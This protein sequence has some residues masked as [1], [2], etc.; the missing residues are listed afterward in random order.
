[1]GQDKALMPFLSETLIERLIRHL[2]PLKV[3][4]LITTNQPEK[5]QFLGLPL[6]PDRQPGSGAL[7][8]LFTALE[9]ARTPLV[10][11]VACDM[12]FI[13]SRLLDAQG[14]ILTDQ[15]WDA[16]VPRHHSGCEP[17]HA[18]YRRQA[19]LPAI[20]GALAAGHRR[21]DSW[22]GEA[23]MRWLTQDEIA[24]YD[25]D[26]LCFVNLNTLDEFRQA[27]ILAAKRMN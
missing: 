11:V 25:P 20:R 23:R 24:P 12:P 3:E 22:F 7:A 16:V 27:E 21:V 2:T 4:T 17:F 1:M 9:A 10:A 26:G 14:I 15:D 8:G 13:S 5:Y 19:C 18:V 6:I